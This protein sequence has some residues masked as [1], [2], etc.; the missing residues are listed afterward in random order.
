VQAAEFLIS[1][2]GRRT[3][4]DK[5]SYRHCRNLTGNV[6]AMLCKWKILQAAL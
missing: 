4:E 2:A 3:T 5:I 6:L 1:M